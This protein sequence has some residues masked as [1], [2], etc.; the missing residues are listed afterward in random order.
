M[1]YSPKGKLLEEIRLAETPSNLAFG[2]SDLRSLYVTA[3]T[4]RVSRPARRE[5][6]AAI[7]AAAYP[8]HPLLGVGALIFPA[9]DPILLVERGREPLKGYGRCRAGWW[10]PARSWKTPC[11][12]G[13]A[14]KP[15]CA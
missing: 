5:R 1:I 14:K 15:A 10:K 8:K 6:R 13:S 11:A 2:D 4:R 3:R 12:R 9:R 7:L